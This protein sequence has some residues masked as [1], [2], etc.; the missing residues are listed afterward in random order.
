V[1]EQL[2]PSENQAD[3]KKKVVDAVKE[4][5]R[6]LGNRPAT[7]RKYYVHPAVLE[8]YS[9]GSLFDA[10]KKCEGERREEQCVMRLV[11]QY[12]DKLARDEEA[13]RDFSKQLRESIRRGA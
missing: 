10:L 12:V 8:A 1:L 13:S 9:D 11:T 4:V 7:C 2:G 6:R 3:T 5:S